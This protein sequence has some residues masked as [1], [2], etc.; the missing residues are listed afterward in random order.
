MEREI[1]IIKVNINEIKPYAGNAKKH[2]KE[3]VEQIKQS[4][5][6]FGMNDPIAIDEN[7]VVIEG[8]GRLMALKLLNFEEVPCIRLSHLSEADKR[9][10]ILEHNKSTLN[11]GY[12]EELLKVEMDFLKESAFDL[13]LTGFS[14][15]EISALFDTKSKAKEDD[16]DPTPPTNPLSRL[17]DIWLIG[18]HRLLCGDST[19]QADVDKLMDGK[20][21][22]MIFTDPPWNVNYGTQVHHP[23]WRKRNILNDN[24][25]AEDFNF[26][27]TGA[28]KT[29]KE[30]LVAGGMVYIVMSAQEWGNLCDVLSGLDYYWSSTIIWV[31]DTHVMGMKDYHT[32]YEPLWYGWLG[33]AP[34]VCPMKTDRKQNDV[35]EIT[36][37]KCSEEHPTMK[38]VELVARAIGNSSLVGDL[39]IDLFGGSGTTLL[40]AEQTDRVCNMMELDPKYC[41]VIAKRYI[42]I[43]ESSEGVFLLRDGKQYSYSEVL[44]VNGNA[45]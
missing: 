28:F 40:A 26:F 31:K 9:A 2:P 1:Q 24:M 19:K 45:H 22:R 32:R 34:R 33:N 8:H 11:T 39:V 23:S 3:Q 27:L 5:L 25:S 44:E 6:H 43:K 12:D 37:P 14:P 36:R 17:G 30:V 16:F 10:Y 15:T 13:N 29:M 35:W 38:P 4:I 20:K 7:N 42:N 21:A 18:K 41:D